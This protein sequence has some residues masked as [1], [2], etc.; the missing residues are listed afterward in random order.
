MR[1][2]WRCGWP[3]LISELIEEHKKHLLILAILRDAE[4]DPALGAKYERAL[5][6]LDER[7]PVRAIDADADL[8]F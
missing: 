8:P 5:A 2:R 6:I 3:D 7:R 4:R 1:L